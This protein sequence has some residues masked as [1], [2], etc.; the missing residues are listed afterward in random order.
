MPLVEIVME[1]L[2]RVVEVVV[3]LLEVELAEFARVNWSSWVRRQAEEQKAVP[4]VCLSQDKQKSPRRKSM[5]VEVWF[6]VQP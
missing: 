1:G 6:E 5:V 4:F 3:V 2:C